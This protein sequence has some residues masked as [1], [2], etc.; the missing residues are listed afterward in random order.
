MNMIAAEALEYG[1]SIMILSDNHKRWSL[2][3]VRISLG[4]AAS[5]KLQLF[6]DFFILLKYIIFMRRLLLN[7]PKAA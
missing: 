3:T 7:K 2:L 1:G 5:Y 6:S 4:A